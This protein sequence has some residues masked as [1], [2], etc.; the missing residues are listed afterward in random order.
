M[1][2]VHDVIIVGAGPA[3]SA[4]A[5]E[6]AR[7]GFSVLLLE[8]R[9]FPRDKACG[10]GLT[11]RAQRLLPA[12]VDDIVLSRATSVHLRVGAGLSE[13]FTSKEA[14]IWMVR[15]RDLDQRLAEEAAR[16]GADLHDGEAALSVDLR[17]E[18]RVESARAGYRA[19]V[20]IGADGAESRVAR[21]LGLPRPTRWMVG[22][23][24][25]V[26]VP[27]EMP[28]GRAVV[29]LS[30]PDGYAWAFPRGDVYNVG[31]GT[32]APA[33]ARGLRSYLG[34]FVEELR[35]PPRRPIAPVGHRIPTG[36][37]PGPLHSGAAMLA[38]D[39]AGVADPFF[40]EGISYALLSGRLAAGAAADYLM[41]R[42]PDLSVYTARLR[43]ALEAD[44]RAWRATAAVVYRFPSA[45][46]RLLA[47]S[48]WLRRLVERTI[49]GEVSLSKRLPTDDR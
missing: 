19:R 4:A 32:F 37:A 9:R 10:G 16:L 6:L 7:G 20:L 17:R 41:G 25:E 14:A 45:C 38:G 15:R 8:A 12:R 42:A 5:A 46:V 49:A 39:A 30:V 13:V 29:D 22:L 18:V 47:A 44:A 35:I 43:A 48:S 36:L 1:S 26:P 27:P 3:G 34:R 24:A 31:A 11:P 28:E 21:W 33:R 40:A 23:E 2:R